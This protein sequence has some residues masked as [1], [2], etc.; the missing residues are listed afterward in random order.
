M[1]EDKLSDKSLQKVMVIKTLAQTDSQEQF[2]KMCWL[3]QTIWL[4]SEL[5]YCHKL[6]K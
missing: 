4:I 6:A 3:L 5:Y 2:S 1:T